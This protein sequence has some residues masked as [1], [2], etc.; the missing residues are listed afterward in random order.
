MSM[1]G[2]LVIVGML[3]YRTRDPGMWRWMAS[4][5]S[6]DGE[7]AVSVA[8]VAPAA[9]KQ[10]A[11]E[12]K[13]NQPETPPQPELP[14]EPVASGPT[15]EDPDEREEVKEEFQVISDKSLYTQKVE[16]LAYNRLLRW[17][18]AQTWDMMHKRADRKIVFN[19]FVQSPDKF[20]G[21]LVE[22]ELNARRAIEF[23][24]PNH[25]GRMLCEVWG[26]TT[27]SKAWLYCGVVVDYPKDMPRGHS[28]YERVR[29]T[30]Y[31]FKLQGYERA[32]AKPG[33]PPLYTPMII[34]RIQWKKIEAPAVQKSDWMVAIILITVLLVVGCI[35]AGTFLLRS[36]RGRKPVILSAGPRPGALS[37]DD[38]MDRAES[39]DAPDG[40]A[41]DPA[42]PP[43][44][45]GDGPAGGDRP[46]G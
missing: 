30:G 23:P 20:R 35:A 11:G 4:D 13:T 17:T 1:L 42:S 38:W 14:A 32:G 10:P 27:E 16:M 37:I 28:I 29:L 31:F 8:D 2:M 9:A 45:G 6:G 25:P 34:G 41:D 44:P 21:K 19:D 46:S 36:R 39:G 15:D 24:D 12:A 3:I 22:L 43:Q 40:P 5:D 33:D 18:E 7:V 26:W